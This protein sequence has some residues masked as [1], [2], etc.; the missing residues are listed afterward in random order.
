MSETADVRA[1]GA[2]FV[3]SR[4]FLLTAPMEYVLTFPPDLTKA[5]E[6]FRV[7]F[8]GMVIRCERVPE[9]QDSFGIAVRN[10]AGLYLTRD[11]AANLTAMDGKRSAAMQ[12]ALKTGTWPAAHRILDRKESGLDGVSRNWCVSAGPWR[13]PVTDVPCL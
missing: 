8:F 1:A 11:E 3:A 9:S 13:C 2:V 5:P 7:R 6:P 10:T 4:P 12:P